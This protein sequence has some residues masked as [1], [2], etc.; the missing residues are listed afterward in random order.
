MSF[1]VAAF[2]PQIDP[3]TSF[4]PRGSLRAEWENVSRYSHIL[5]SL[6][7]YQSAEIGIPLRQID[8]EEWFDRGVGRHVEV[9]DDDEFLAFEGFVNEVV[10]RT[11]PLETT[12]GPLLDIGNRVSGIYSQM[13]TS[14]NPPT[15]TP[16]VQTLIVEDDVSQQEYGII[17]K[18][19]A[20]GQRTQVSAEQA[21]DVFL[22]VNKEPATNKRF[23]NQPSEAS[24][25]SLKLLGYW[26]RL[27]LY[28]YNQTVVSG[29]TTLSDKLKAILAA[30]PNGFLSSEL[31]KIVTNLSLTHAYEN[32]SMKA[33]SLIKSIV[34]DGDA[35]DNP[36]TFG[37]YAG[38]T[39][40]Y[41]PIP[42]EI[43]YKQETADPQA[44]VFTFSGDKLVRPWRVMPGKHIMYTD[45]LIGRVPPVDDFGRD[46]R[47]ELIKQVDFTAPYTLAMDGNLESTITQKLN[48]LMLGG[49]A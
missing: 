36:Y 30:E 8:A 28:I 48:R 44:D 42:T 2:Q 1:F 45:F 38:R 12:I 10:I 46:R 16:G 9:Y 49:R 23:S 34:A 5:T 26:A 32:D 21:R 15:T 20:L 18:V 37:I 19:L 35:A 47:V 13:D 31:G 41:G 17:E 24:S 43:F 6:E 25:V 29:T 22:Q 40:E 3:G 11:G 33:W 27:E 14:V 4:E 7:G 39:P